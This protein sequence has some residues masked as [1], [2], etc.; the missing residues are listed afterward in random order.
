VDVLVLPTIPR[1]PTI[2]E[3]AA[4][5]IAVNS[6]LGTYTNFVNLLDL[7][8]VTVPVPAPDTSDLPAR[9][10]T[11]LTLIA[12]AWHDATLVTMAATIAG[13]PASR[14]PR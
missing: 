6:M 10:P 5:P 9:P 3:V 11:S 13:A 8:A 7:C 14:P 1:V 2:T 4:E 12:P